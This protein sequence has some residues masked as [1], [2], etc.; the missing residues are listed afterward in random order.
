M[1]VGTAFKIIGLDTSQEGRYA[2][3]KKGRVVCF[4][5][6]ILMSKT[7]ASHQRC[8]IK[9]NMRTYLKSCKRAGNNKQS[10]DTPLDSFFHGTLRNQVGMEV[11]DFVVIHADYDFDYNLI[12]SKHSKTWLYW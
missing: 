7:F 6:T 10:V 2:L 3:R 12:Q 4:P 1:I 8:T 5:N 11:N 9:I